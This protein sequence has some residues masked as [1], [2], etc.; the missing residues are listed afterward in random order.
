MKQRTLIFSS[1]GGGKSKP[2]VS[3]GLRAA[4]GL[5]GGPLLLF[6]LPAGPAILG[7]PLTPADGAVHRCG[8]LS[9]RHT[10]CL[11]GGPG[12][13]PPHCPRSWLPRR[14]RSQL[15]GGSGA[16]ATCVVPAEA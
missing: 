15:R 12:S 10:V 7:F 14:L 2:Q 8:H 13:E 4:E 1:P 6:R 5:Y 16:E 11:R 3:A 9:V